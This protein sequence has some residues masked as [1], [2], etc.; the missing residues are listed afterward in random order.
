MPISVGI[1]LAFGRFIVGLKVLI[2]Q[3]F[4]ACLLQ[5]AS[6]QA[7]LNHSHQIVNQPLVPRIA[8]ATNEAI[9]FPQQVKHRLVISLLTANQGQIHFQ[10]GL[11]PRE[12]EGLQS[13]FSFEENPL[14]LLIKIEG[15]AVLFS[16]SLM[17]S[18]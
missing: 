5:A 15:S 3:D 7:I 14:R 6:H 10:L 4:K 18:F 13:C 2:Q 1:E 12:T 9:L 17:A 11:F 16:V 8:I